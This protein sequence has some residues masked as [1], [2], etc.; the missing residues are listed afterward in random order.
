[1]T[2]AVTQKLQ[3]WLRRCLVLC[4]KSGWVGWQQATNNLENLGKAAQFTYSQ[5]RESYNLPGSINCIWIGVALVLGKLFSIL[6]SAA[7]WD[8]GSVMASQRRL[9]F[10]TSL[11][12]SLQVLLWVS[13]WQLRCVNEL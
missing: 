5:S 8:F 12:F 6:N 3:H 1:V 11:L 2:L 9:V 10:F 7:G 13:I 4:L